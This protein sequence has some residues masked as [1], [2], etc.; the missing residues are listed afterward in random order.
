[1][2]APKEKIRITF[3]GPYFVGK[4]SLINRICNNS[5]GI[6]HYPTTNFVNYEF[7]YKVGDEDV[8]DILLIDTF[9]FD[10]QQLLQNEDDA[11]E[12]ESSLFYLENELTAKE[13]QEKLSDV[14]NNKEFLDSKDKLNHI[15]KNAPKVKNPEYTHAIILVHDL[16][17]PKTLEMVKKYFVSFKNAENSA[18][19]KVNIG[20]GNQGHSTIMKVW[21]NKYDSECLVKPPPNESSK[22]FTHPD[23]KECEFKK[24]SAMTSTNLAVN[25]D[26]LIKQI[27]TEWI[28][29]KKIIPQER[30]SE[31][32]K[33]KIDTWESK[34][35]S[36]YFSFGFCWGGN[37]PSDEDRGKV[38]SDDEY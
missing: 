18:N 25:F 1:M 11:E 8:H 19:K 22:E 36:S 2:E 3:V 10:H 37:L 7:K 4:T 5:F 21:G 9:P 30:K 6:Y 28:Q 14:M 17:E 29:E 23:L 15:D 38:D 27:L 33:K 24:V 35:V 13:M 12:D 31:R 16:S 32:K 20:S 26:E 34:P